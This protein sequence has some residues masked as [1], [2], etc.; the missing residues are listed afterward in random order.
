MAIS[1]R[2]FQVCLIN[3]SFSSSYDN[4]IYFKDIEERTEYFKNVYNVSF[5][6]SPLVNF[7]F[8]D[9]L[10]CECVINAN[11]YN[12]SNF[13]SSVTSH[14]YCIVRETLY[15][16]DKTTY[17]DRF[18]F[19]K[20]CKYITAT[21]IQLKLK[22]DVFTTYL[23]SQYVG[24]MKKC[25]IKRACLNR[26]VKVD[27]QYCF[28]FAPDSLL[29]EK[30][31]LTYNKRLVKSTKLD[32]E[33]N[34][35]NSLLNNWLKENV[36]YYACFFIDPSKELKFY[37]YASDIKSSELKP[38]VNDLFQYL[39]QKNNKSNFTF[40]WLPVLKSN[41][42]MY[43]KVEGFTAGEYIMQTKIT[44]NT[45]RTLLTFF[46]NQS[47]TPYIIDAKYTKFSLLKNYNSEVTIIDNKLYLKSSASSYNDRYSCD[48]L[49]YCGNG[50][51][52]ILSV[53]IT[54]FQISEPISVFLG[55]DFSLDSAS[56]IDSYYNVNYNEHKRSFLLDEIGSQNPKDLSDSICYLN[57]R[58]NS[59]SY[60]YNWDYMGTFTFD[61]GYHRYQYNFK[62]LE[63]INPSVSRIYIYLSPM[64]LY[65][66]GTTLNY[67]GVV[68]SADMSLIYY[69]DNYSNYIANNKNAWLQTQLNIGSS[70]AKTSVKAL[71]AYAVTG[72]V[73]ASV[74]VTVA[75]SAINA[76]TTIANYN[77]NIDNLKA[78]PQSIN[79]VQ[80]N[81]FLNDLINDNGIYLEEWE[82]L[83][84]DKQK[85]DDY[86]S[87]FGYKVNRL[88]FLSQYI[89]I[90]RYWNYIQAYVEILPQDI[91]KF[92][93]KVEE[94]IK[95]AFS[96]GIRFW[97][98]NDTSYEIKFD[99][100]QV[101]LENWIV[102][103]KQ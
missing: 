97:N 78:S 27:N 31:D 14:N 44:S 74:G 23:P 40:V 37:S 89:N 17:D 11:T 86:C 25:D 26:F 36:L 82:C 53:V 51:N 62:Y 83:P 57:L 90:R 33:Q 3:V 12:G 48:S 60:Q 72:N 34:N 24:Y 64:G 5:N 87:R 93:S 77:L 2:T 16:E 61:T 79:N 39:K 66:S 47:I 6:D 8:G 73:G 20:E 98:V 70:I 63:A 75:S 88:D 49:L 13:Q 22:L 45:L 29:L 69:N 1:K 85:F 28:N 102:N 46:K 21:Q 43:V 58:M 55:G 38:I 65:T 9:G 18:Y 94:E 15:V 59:D 30:E 91:F 99:M 56:I 76:V 71:G 81:F 67:T 32:L 101:N 7:N 10:N 100:S 35:K 68:T 4:V 80:G 54:P 42:E 95:E 50:I 84:S 19:I 41:A 103:E 96:N 52:D 92:N